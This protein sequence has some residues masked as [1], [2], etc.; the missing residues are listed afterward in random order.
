MGKTLGV[1]L[2]MILVH[3][4]PAVADPFVFTYSYSNLL[5]GK[6][7]TTLSASQLRAATEESFGVWS[8][9]APLEFHEVPDAGPPPSDADY[10]AAGTPDIRIGHHANTAF[11]HAFFPWAP[12]GLAHD[13]HLRTR[14]DDRFYWGLGDD[15]SPFAV[16]VMATMVHEL[17]H[18]L[19][20]GHH[21]GVP[22]LMNGTV[23]WAYPG[24]GFAFLFP[25][26]ILNIQALYGAGIGSVHP[27]DD[28][29]A[30]PE[31]GTV[32]LLSLP[33]ASLIR[34]RYRRGRNAARRGCQLPVGLSSS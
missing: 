3:A 11:S 1:L 12:G 27:L 14:Y 23:V 24:L 16:D 8:R 20:L 13:V 28:V 15:P 33:L 7:D 31:P 22:S 10:P 30:T 34:L 18:A 5:D 29:L 19:G 9:Y 2:A 6:L 32:L 25:D 21:E 4:T 17:G 26:D